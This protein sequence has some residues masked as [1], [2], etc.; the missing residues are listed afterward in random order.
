MVG[1]IFCDLEKA[2]DCVNHK[3]LLS[4]LEFYGV[5]WKAKLWFESYFRIRY[6]RVLNTSN[7]FNQND[8]SAWEDI[9]HGVPQG[10]ILGPLLF[11]FYINDLPTTI[12]DKS[13]P[14][15]FANDTS[16]LVTSPNKNDFQINITAAFN[17]INEWL[18]ANLLS[19]NFN[20][21]HY[22]QFT[23]N[24]KP[25]T[26]I[27]ITYDNKQITTISN[28]KFLGIII[29]DTINWKYHTSLNNLRIVYY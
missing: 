29:N 12:N 8:I 27:K 22:I 2:L 11:L 24:N 6:Q 18:N 21:T 25:N 3:I 5:K 7:D 23:T 14:I 1:G 9:K 26:N 13:I 17:C 4:K 15:L 19:I 10:S 28:I 20:K 16:I